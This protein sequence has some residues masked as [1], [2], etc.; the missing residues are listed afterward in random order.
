VQVDV[1][2]L[3]STGGTTAGSPTEEEKKAATPVLLRV[4][5]DLLDRVD[6]RLSMRAVKIPR[7]TWI[8]EAILEQLEREAS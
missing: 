2:A 4:P 6:R 3:I 5:T 1:E 7:H 8:L